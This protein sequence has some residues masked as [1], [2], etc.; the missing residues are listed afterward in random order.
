MSKRNN[1]EVKTLSDVVG[2]GKCT[3]GCNKNENSNA[4]NY[5]DKLDAALG[6]IASFINPYPRSDNTVDS[7]IPYFGINNGVATEYAYG[8]YPAE[9][10]MYPNLQMYANNNDIQKLYKTADGADTRIAEAV[11]K[12]I[13]DYDEFILGM[14]K[15]NADVNDEIVNT[16]VKSADMAKSCLMNSI[17]RF[18]TQ[19]CTDDEVM[20]LITDFCNGHRSNYS[21]IYENDG[22]A[23]KEDTINAIKNYDDAITQLLIYKLSGLTR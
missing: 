6:S 3:C 15:R 8:N 16:L 18:V 20:H 4:S 23:S 21:Y 10:H 17:M 7:N 11:K 22:D 9:Q 12:F 14:L 19:P 1:D 13:T 5:A 2:A